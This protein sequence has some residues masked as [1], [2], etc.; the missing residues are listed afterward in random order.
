MGGEWSKTLETLPDIRLKSTQFI[1]NVAL[2]YK[3][4]NKVTEFLY[5]LIIACNRGYTRAI[6]EFYDTNFIRILAVGAN[7]SH[8]DSVTGI[9]LDM[10]DSSISLAEDQAAGSLTSDPC[11]SYF[12]TLLGIIT[13]YGLCGAHK[14]TDQAVLYFAKDTP[15]AQNVISMMCL[16]G[17]YRAQHDRHR[18]V[19]MYKK[20]FEILPLPCTLYKIA[21]M[22]KNN[23]L[24]LEVLNLCEEYPESY[25]THLVLGCMH[26]FGHLLPVN[27]PV[28][29]GYLSSMYNIHPH[30]ISHV[31]DIIIQEHF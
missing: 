29:I 3:E 20:A 27:V 9:V 25:H 14:D 30:N 13:H 1:F 19:S 15:K 17:V 12:Y 24:F 16:A 21:V 31:R 23:D 11:V 8:A 10:C 5:F 26:L 28:A 6:V 22:T 7:Q 2:E 4:A 18:A